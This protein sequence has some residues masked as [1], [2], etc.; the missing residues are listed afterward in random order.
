MSADIGPKIPTS[1]PIRHGIAQIKHRVMKTCQ[2]TKIH[3]NL[4]ATHLHCSLWRSCSFQSCLTSDLTVN[5]PL[6]SLV[7]KEDSRERPM[8]TSMEESCDHHSLLVPKQ[9]KDETQRSQGLQSN[10]TSQTRFLELCKILDAKQ[11]NKILLKLASSSL[12]KAIIRKPGCSQQTQIMPCCPSVH[13]KW[14]VGTVN[15]LSP[16]HLTLHTQKPGLA[17]ISYL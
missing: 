16:S 13:T 10:L 15:I 5:R 8:E 12:G 9:G 14:Y 17:I 3:L 7:H 4:K 11:T 6:W 1:Y 2:T